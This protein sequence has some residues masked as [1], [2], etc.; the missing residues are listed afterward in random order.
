MEREST[1]SKEHDDKQRSKLSLLLCILH[2]YLFHRKCDVWSFGMCLV[3]LA[4]LE[5]PW[6]EKKFTEPIQVV[7][8][9]SM[10][11]LEG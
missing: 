10:Y 9:L 2:W 3:E 6:Y 11:D 1:T 8:E 7:H 5:D 4:N